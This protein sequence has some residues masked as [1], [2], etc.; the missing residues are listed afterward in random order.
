[1]KANSLHAD[2]KN[3]WHFHYVKNDLADEENLLIT[4]G[5]SKIKQN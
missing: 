5:L 1:M 3:V 4:S 2:V